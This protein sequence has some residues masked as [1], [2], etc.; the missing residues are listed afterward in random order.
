MQL[1]TQHLLSDTTNSFLTSGIV[2][3]AVPAEAT[4]DNTLLPSGFT[5]IRAAVDY[6]KTGAVARLAGV[7]TNAASARF[8]DNGNDPRHLRSPLPLH[9][10]RKLAAPE[11]AIKTVEQPAASFGGAM[12]EDRGSFASR[13]S[14]RLR[15]KGRAVTLWDCERLVLEHFPSLYRV[16]C[17]NHASPDSFTAAGHVMLVVV[18]RMDNKNAATRLTPCA[19]KNLLEEIGAFL[20]SRALSFVEFHPVNPSYEAVCVRCKVRFRR[21]LDFGYYRQQL[22]EDLKRF[23]SPWAYLDQADILFGRGVHS[24]AVIRFIEELPYVD[25]LED[26][27]L[28]LPAATGVPAAVP[29]SPRAILT[30]AD[31]HDIEEAGL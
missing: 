9:T 20:S 22:Q 30:S 7:R 31:E 2:A 25:F 18:P 12:A 24:S 8:L 27:R 28:D 4:T 19:D 26:L 16:K 11:A 3:I 5:W 29:S 10:I 14:E 13:V 15:H 21:E 6:G 1:G 17:I 23:F